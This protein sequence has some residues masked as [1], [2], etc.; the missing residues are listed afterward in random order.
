M[1]SDAPLSCAIT[2][3]NSTTVRAHRSFSSQRDEF[4]RLVHLFGSSLLRVRNN[5]AYNESIAGESITKLTDLDNLVQFY[6]TPM[7]ND[8]LI[9]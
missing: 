3:K 5:P 8:A 6:I 4:N 7:P 2:R 1:E 9:E